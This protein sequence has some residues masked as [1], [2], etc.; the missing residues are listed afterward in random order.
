MTAT[1][2]LSGV[3]DYMST[4][5]FALKSGWLPIQSEFSCGRMMGWKSGRLPRAFRAPFLAGAQQGIRK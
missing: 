5:G 1:A 4:S 2:M 3:S